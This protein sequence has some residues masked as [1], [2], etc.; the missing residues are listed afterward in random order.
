MSRVLING[1]FLHNPNTGS[2]QYLRLLLK[3]LSN[4][5]SGMDI[6]VIA[7]L[8]KKLPESCTLHVRNTVDRQINKFYFEQ[9]VVPQTAKQ[10]GAD[11]LHIPYWAPPFK[12]PCPMVV[13]VHDIIPLLLPEHNRSLFHRV[14]TSLAAAATQGASHIITDSNKSHDDIVA[15]LQVKDT[16]V[17]TIHLG[18]DD[19]YSPQQNPVESNKVR[20]NYNLPDTYVLYLGGFQRHKNL[21]HLLAAWTWAQ[22]IA[23]EDCPLIIAGRLP[24]NPDGHLYDD[25]PDIANSL[26]INDTVR[27]IGEVKEEDK[28]ALYQLASCF[29]FPS[30]YEGFGLPPLEAMACGVPVI[31]TGSGALK[32]IVGDAAYL[33][34]DPVEARE[35]GAAMISLIVDETLASDLQNRG[36]IQSAKFSWEQTAVD[37]LQI[38]QQAMS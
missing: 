28:T 24:K 38:Y 9:I 29:V 19:V 11:V 30:S 20:T 7:P 4:P 23:S 5:G 21:R 22:P 17:H 18:V 8:S 31:T 3:Y 15:N 25:L 1:W 6:H 34:S 33:I 36:L 32:E 14:Y 10:I 27:F 2:G 35:L 13:T 16:R 37:T 12:S 26:G